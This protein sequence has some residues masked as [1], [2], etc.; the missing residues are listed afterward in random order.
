M[1]KSEE[2]VDEMEF[3]KNTVAKLTKKL[4]EKDEKINQLLTKINS[5]NEITDLVPKKQKVFDTYKENETEKQIVKLYAQGYSS[6]GFI[7]NILNKDY[8]ISISLDTITNL[9]ESLNGDNLM[10]DPMLEKYFIE[11]KKNFEDKN[12]LSKGL[13]A[14]MIYKKFKILEE[15]YSQCLIAATEMEDHRERRMILDSLLKLTEKTASVFSKNILDMFNNGNNTSS[16]YDDKYKKLKEKY[17]S[18][19]KE[20]E[21]KK[22]TLKIKKKE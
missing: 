21:A 15:E 5:E 20:E 22:K 2:R 4:Q 19:N 9:L 10:V 3:L 12:S 11:C 7:F 14:N 16:V 13:F 6:G 1:I 18:D 17:L 8:N